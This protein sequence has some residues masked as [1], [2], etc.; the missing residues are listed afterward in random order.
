MNCDGGDVERV[1][2]ATSAHLGDA[3][4][5][6]RRASRHFAAPG[7]ANLQ[8]RSADRTSGISQEALDTRCPISLDCFVI[9]WDAATSV[10]N[11]S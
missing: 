11:A 8:W 6:P 7:H 3:P 1:E 2:S 5:L 4:S 10:P 9:I